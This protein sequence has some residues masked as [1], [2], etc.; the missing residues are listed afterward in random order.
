MVTIQVPS[1]AILDSSEDYLAEGADAT[2][3]RHTVRRAGQT[4]YQS[5]SHNHKSVAY[6]WRTGQEFLRIKDMVRRGKWTAWKNHSG[7]ASARKIEMYMRIARGFESEEMAS[8]AAPTIVA[9]DAV[10][11]RRKTKV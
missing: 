6:A 2:E 3:F 8:I 1:L 5:E 10:I 4:F 7:F 11:R 9:A